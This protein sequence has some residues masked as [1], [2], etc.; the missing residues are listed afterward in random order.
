VCPWSGLPDF[1]NLTIKYIPDKKCIELKSLKY[2]L[3]SY[4]NVGIFYEHVVNKILE[5][6]VSVCDPVS[7]TIEAEFSIRGGLKT[8]VKAEYKKGK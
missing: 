8:T 5:D 4:R 7:M 6:L 1:A 2:Y 3:H